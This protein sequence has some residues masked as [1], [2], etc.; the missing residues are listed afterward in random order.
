MSNKIEKQVEEITS[1]VLE[2]KE[3]TALEIKELNTTID[4]LENEIVEIKA[5]AVNMQVDKNEEK[6]VAAKSLWTA[7]KT[8]FDE[9]GAPV[10]ALID[11]KGMTTAGDSAGAG[12]VEELASSIL[13][14]A[15]EDYAIT[16]DM[17]VETVSSP[18]YSKVVQVGR[19]Q[20]KWGGENTTNVA[21]GKTA[22]PTFV[23]VNA[24]FAKLTIDNYVTNE[25]LKDPVFD[26]EAFLTNDVRVQAG[27]VMSQGFIDGDG[28]GENPKG[29][30]A[31]FD[32]TE[33]AKDDD[34][35]G[36]EFFG[37]ITSDGSLPADDEALIDL[38]RDLEGEVITAYL[39]KAKYYVN[40]AVFKRL[41]KMKDSTGVHYLQKDI[42]GKA[43]GTL[44]GYPVV[45]DANLQ[46]DSSVGNRPVLFGD[47]EKAFKRIN[48]VNLTMLRNP[49]IVPG[50]VN[51]HWELRVGTMI[52]DSNALKAIAIVAA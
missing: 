21:P 19:S 8:G 5:G 7:A 48:H 51:F 45:V 44:F 33:S 36:K 34:T 40:R 50:N 2:S 47:M 39:E 15:Q 11:E 14:P 3:A 20:A 12:I 35:R 1:A 41:A 23:T 18:N 28:T 26:I 43:K 32:D 16:A 31:H 27:R 49:Y 38:L 52:G 10:N 46:D 13:V 4:K 22:T 17:G 37:E 24:K 6:E 29:I 42:S 25:S 30:L 9:K